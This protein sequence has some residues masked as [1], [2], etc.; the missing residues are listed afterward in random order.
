LRAHR[1]VKR[2]QTYVWYEISLP[3]DIVEA[4]GLKDGSELEI[5]LVVHEGKQAILL[6]P[7]DKT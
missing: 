1:Q 7:V 4:L 2:G 5:K 6:V 3:K